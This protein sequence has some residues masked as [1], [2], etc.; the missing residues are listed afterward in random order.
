MYVSEVLLQTSRYSMVHI[1]TKKYPI[2]GL[3]IRINKKYCFGNGY[4]WKTL[5][6][7]RMV[8]RMA[9]AEQQQTHETDSVNQEILSLFLL[10]C[11]RFEFTRDH[12]TEKTV[13]TNLDI[14]EGI[15]YS[16]LLT[17]GVNIL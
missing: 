16:E 10:K 4:D 2:T 11:L 8:N 17:L 15:V 12:C 9:L 5:K 14:L 1:Y 3:K 6:K 7:K 13:V